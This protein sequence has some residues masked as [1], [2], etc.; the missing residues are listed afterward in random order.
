MT[1]LVWQRVEIPKDLTEADELLEKFGRWA[2][3]RY[4]KQTCASAERRYKIPNHWGDGYIPSPPMP[5]FRAINVHRALLRVPY[6]FRRILFAHYVPQRLPMEAQRRRMGIPWRVW[7]AD[8][9]TGLRMFWNLW[10]KN[11]HSSVS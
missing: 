1:R 10:Q 9:V 2:Q 8:H 11:A 6:R 3:D 7:D 4:R 5:D